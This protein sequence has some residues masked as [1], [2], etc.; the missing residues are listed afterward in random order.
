MNLYDVP[1][2]ISSGEVGD[3]LD[4][5]RLLCHRRDL[6]VAAGAELLHLRGGGGAGAVV[7]TGA[8]KSM[9][10]PS[11]IVIQSLINGGFDE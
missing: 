1:M 6:A 11:L 5:L 4:H 9:G 8:G 2:N 10:N 7:E 3:H